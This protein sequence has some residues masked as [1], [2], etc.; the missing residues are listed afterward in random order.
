MATRVSI[1][2]GVEIS[3][4]ANKQAARR[5]HHHCRDLRTATVGTQIQIQIHIQIQKHIQIPKC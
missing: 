1:D 5:D 4:A 2:V 3:A